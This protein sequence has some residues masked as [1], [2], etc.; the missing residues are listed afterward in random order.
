VAHINPEDLNDHFI[1]I[2]HGAVVAAQYDTENGAAGSAATNSM[3]FTFW[4]FCMP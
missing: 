1:S 3:R 4:M 2:S